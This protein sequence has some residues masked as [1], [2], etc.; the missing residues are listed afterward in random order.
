MQYLHQQQPNGFQTQLRRRIAYGENP[1]QVLEDLTTALESLKIS[2]TPKP[3]ECPADISVHR[4]SA[5]KLLLQ[6]LYEMPVSPQSSTAIRSYEAFLTATVEL[7]RAFDVTDSGFQNLWLSTI[8]SV[9]PSSGSKLAPELLSTCLELRLVRGNRLYTNILVQP[10]NP[11]E[12]SRQLS[13][14]ARVETVYPFPQ[15][16]KKQPNVHI[17][18]I[19]NHPPSTTISSSTIKRNNSRV[20][21]RLKNS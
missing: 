19:R 4:G 14:S 3:I 17:R 15:P 12:I 18:T 13:G 6:Q 11:P 16:P 5:F 21:K 8:D 9:K 20:S 1:D 7:Q 10:H 2:E